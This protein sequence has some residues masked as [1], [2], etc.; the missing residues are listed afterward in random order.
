MKP[1]ILVVEDDAD[2]REVLEV[3]LNVNGYDSTLCVNGREALEALESFDAPPQAILLDL[4]MP[5]MTGYEFRATQQSEGR[6]AAVPVIVMSAERDVDRN[7]L[8]SVV[9]LPKPFDAESLL[10]RIREIDARA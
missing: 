3:I 7:A 10:A 4:D 6:I 9:Y 2:V 1:R 5:E 8:G